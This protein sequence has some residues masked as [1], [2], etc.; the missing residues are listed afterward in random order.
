MTNQ[1]GGK[2]I[3]PWPVLNVNRKKWT[4]I[5][6]Y[7]TQ[8]II[9]S[10]DKLLFESSATSWQT[11]R[12]KCCLCQ[13]DKNENLIPSSKSYKREEAGY[14]NIAT[15]R[16]VFHEINALTI[17]MDIKGLNDESGI[18]NTLRLNNANITTHADLCLTTVTLNVLR[19]DVYLKGVMSLK[20]V[21][22]SLH[23]ILLIQHQT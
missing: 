15:N 20:Q 17:P 8:S 14:K 13:E 11:D 2:K 23:V 5:T 21:Q 9:M 3:V 4:E 19:S 12:N 22:V 1:S 7:L 6:E 16:P 18:E 10:V